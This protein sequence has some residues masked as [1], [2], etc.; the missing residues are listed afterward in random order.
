MCN[1]LK[2][3]IIERNGGKFGTHGPSRCLC[4]V[5]F[6]SDSLRSVGVIWCTLQDYWLLLPQF[7]S[8]FNQTFNFLEKMCNLEEIQVITFLAIWQILKVNGTLQIS[9]LIYI[10]IIHKAMLVLSGKRS[11]RVSAPLGLLFWLR[12]GGGTHA[13]VTLL[14]KQSGF[15]SETVPSK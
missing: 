1:I 14:G 6:M 15:T 10:G 9:Y 2:R 12:G 11:S 5:L 4:K 8:N 3:L 13:R 7:S